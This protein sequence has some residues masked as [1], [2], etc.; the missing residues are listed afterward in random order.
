MLVSKAVFGTGNAPPLAKK[1]KLQPEADFFGSSDN[2]KTSKSTNE[3]LH[4]GP[5][6]H[7]NEE[8]AV[9][10]LIMLGS[11]A[12]LG[13]GNAPPLAKKVKLQPERDFCASSDNKKTSKSTNEGSHNGPEIRVN[14]DDAV[15]GLFESIQDCQ[16][17][18]MRA[19]SWI[20]AKEVTPQ[21]GPILAN[22]MGL[23]KTGQTPALV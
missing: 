7:A 3:G 22:N 14:E 9:K 11:K 4:N 12:V 8:D 17:D 16:D 19:F 6:I 20:H 13:T 5:E 18:E 23:G 21:F 15:K 2:K 1:V 10:G